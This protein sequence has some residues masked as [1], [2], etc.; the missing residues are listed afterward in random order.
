MFDSAPQ[1]QNKLGTNICVTE[2]ISLFYKEFLKIERISTTEQK[3][4]QELCI[5]K[6][7]KSQ[8]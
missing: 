3:I 4:E 5:K 2:L 1:S 8:V 6:P 7:W